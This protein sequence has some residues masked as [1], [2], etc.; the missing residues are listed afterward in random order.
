MID[1]YFSPSPIP[2]RIRHEKFSS[3]EQ[4]WHIA[5]SHIFLVLKIIDRQFLVVFLQLVKISLVQYAYVPKAKMPFI[6]GKTTRN[7]C[8][9]EY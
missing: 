2:S 9:Q 4:Y 6:R 5:K 3:L 1:K 7:S 8:V